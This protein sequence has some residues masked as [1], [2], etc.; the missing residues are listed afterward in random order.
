MN[1]S[2]SKNDVTF[3]TLSGY[4]RASYSCIGDRKYSSKTHGVH[5]FMQDLA[6]LDRLKWF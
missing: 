3:E 4:E 2:Q 6:N 5:H 1:R